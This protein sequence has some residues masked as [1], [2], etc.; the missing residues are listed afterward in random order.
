MGT[1]MAVDAGQEIHLKA[2]MTLVLESGTQ[3]SLKV[4]GNFIDINPASVFIKGTMVMVNS[5]GSAGSGS[6][7]S[8]KAPKS[9]KKAEDSKGG[10]DKPITQRAAALIAARAAST[11]FC[12]ICNA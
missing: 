2:G 10:A 6:G 3:I 11:P 9:A 1:R 4:G 7:A 12:E 8:P 5:G